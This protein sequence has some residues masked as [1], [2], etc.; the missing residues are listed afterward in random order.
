[1]VRDGI[2]RV[3]LLETVRITRKQWLMMPV[4]FDSKVDDD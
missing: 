2:S 1:M 3:Q 4:A